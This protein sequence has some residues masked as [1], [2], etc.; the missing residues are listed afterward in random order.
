MNRRRQG[1]DLWVALGVAYLV[2]VQMLV[3]GIALGAQAA[4]SRQL[5]TV[6]CTF[7]GTATAPDGTGQPPD[8]AHLPACC[9][10][11]CSMFG[12]TVAPPPAMASMLVPRQ[13]ARAPVFAF[14]DQPPPPEERRTPGNPRAPP[15]V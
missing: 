8:H 2:V 6:I 7:H 9:V 12:P 10:L 14:A 15:H 13:I 11:G 1:W 4:P 5:S 3:T